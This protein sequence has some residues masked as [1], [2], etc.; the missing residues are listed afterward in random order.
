MKS[1]AAESFAKAGAGSTSQL[2]EKAAWERALLLADAGNDAAVIPSLQGFL[3]TF[4]SSAKSE[5]ARRLLASLLEKTGN[6]ADALTVWDSLVKGFPRSTAL[7]EYLFRRGSALLSLDRQTPALDDF[8]RVT[9]DFPRSPWRFE[10][11]YS[12]GY[13]YDLRGE[14]PRALPFFQ[15]VAQDPSAGEVAERSQLSA[16]ICL[17]NMGS[18]DRAIASLQA[19]RA[20]KPKTVSEGTIVL[21]MEELFIGEKS[22]S[23]QRSGSQRQRRSLPLRTGRAPSRA[24]SGRPPMP[25][26]PCTGWGG[27]TCVSTGS[28][29]RMRSSPLPRDPLAARDTSMLSSARAS[30][31]RCRAMTRAAVALFDRVLAAPG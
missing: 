7:P 10:C 25:R 5:E 11:T 3:R 28:R 20:R 4:P 31:R 27:R 14:Y 2:G 19:L 21:Y 30:A 23:R 29:Q 24:M 17:F 6:Q 1:E 9:R 16:G 18:F 26:R 13:V 22:S 8:Q 15:S 12:I